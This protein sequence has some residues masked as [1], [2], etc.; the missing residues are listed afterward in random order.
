[1]DAKYLKDL[2]PEEFEKLV[3]DL[4]IVSGYTDVRLTGGPGDKGVDIIA[5]SADGIT[6][7]Q[8]KHKMHL[9]TDEIRRFVTKYFGDTSTPR[10]LVYVTSAD[11]P[12]SA[13]DISSQLPPGHRFRLIGQQDLLKLLEA[14]RE[15][16]DRYFGL[17]KRRLS[18]QRLLFSLGV[19]G[20]IVSVLSLFLSFHSVLFRPQA[21]LDQRIHTVESALTSIRDLESHL[22]KMKKDMVET[23]KTTQLINQR[24][25]QAKEL[26]KLTQ[27]QVDAL[28][29][30]LQAQNWH[31]TLF[32][33]A[34]GFILG[35]ASSFVASVLFAKWRQR[36]AL[37]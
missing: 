19:S 36:R 17:A 16:A 11:V 27:T 15:V 21:A 10:S 31:R 26:E 7:I 9:T 33:Y 28:R 23:E 6:A 3:A 30:T 5:K 18:S 12:R 34:M 29:V 2:T 4:L 24:Y 32:N 37:E 14:N 1:M 35:I 8:V 25:T 20:A 13:T 22:E